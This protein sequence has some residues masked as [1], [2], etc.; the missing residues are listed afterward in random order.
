[1]HGARSYHGKVV[2]FTLRV[3]V[4]VSA[5]LDISISSLDGIVVDLVSDLNLNE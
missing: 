4:G 2:F 5:V 3:K 1:L